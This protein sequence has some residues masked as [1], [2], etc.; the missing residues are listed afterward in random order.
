M[1]ATATALGPA[2]IDPAALMRI[3]SLQLRAR[4]VVE[5]F[6]KGLHRSPYHGFS[7]EFSE[8]RQYTPGDDPRYLDWRLYARSDRYY[9]KKFED[10][11]N[12]RCHLIVDGSRSMGYASGPVTKWDYARTAAATV[13]YFLSRQRDAVGLATFEDRVVEY[14]PPRSRPGQL[15]HLM[16]VLHREPQGKATDLI[17]P[18]EEV[19]AATPR[20]G[21]FILFSD[22]LVPTGIVQTSIGNLRAAGHEVV[23]VRVLD[24]EEERFT[25]S[26][27]AMFQDAETGRELF[28]DPRTAAREYRTRFTNHA[29]ALREACV[30]VG[31]DFEQLTTDQPLERVLFDLLLARARRGKG[32]RR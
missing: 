10:E 15:A 16:A 2:F 19:A 22:L 14:L 29:N 31:A 4:V 30:G 20:R 27:A 25:F 23:V 26:T 5:G 18:L 28:V 8:Y 11:T 17:R 7:V 3:K 1:A 9:I 24:P 12:L 32:G 6:E 13:A 21:L